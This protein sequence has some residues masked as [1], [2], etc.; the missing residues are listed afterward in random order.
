[1]TG[2]DHWFEPLADHLGSAYLRY[3]F[4]RGTT[5]EV[6]FLVDALGL[7]SG[8]RVLDVGCGPGRHA[9]ELG[10]LGITVHG[11][12]IS[13]RFVDLATADAPAGVTFERM[14]ARRLTFDGEFDA[15]VS[16]CQGAFGLVGA[17]PGTEA[18]SSIVDPDGEV[19]LGMSRAVRPGGVVAVSAFSAYFV[20]RFLEEHDSFDAAR[21]VNLERTTV[22]S[23]DGAELDVELWTS[24]FTPRELRLLAD[25]CGL[26]VEQL[27]GVR[28]GRYAT[29][30]PD[31]D[32][33]EFL[34][35]ARRPS[36]SGRSSG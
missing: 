34:L 3:S 1:V 18:A 12:D 16:L 21:G 15:A 19:L 11:V 32:H 20:V 28:P 10:R 25:R 26:E 4:T 7:R 14:D 35:V 29:D 13:R 31:L 9:Y 36:P 23:E 33:P 27:W 5:N 8:D 22:R 17:G 6:E 30:A 24:C 2:A